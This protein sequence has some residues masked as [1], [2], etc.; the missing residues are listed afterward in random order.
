[1]REQHTARPIRILRIVTRLNV[2]GPSIHVALLSTALDPRRFA[3]CLVIG[4]PAPT[5][6]DLSGRVEGRPEVR[7]IRVA[8]LRRSIHPW[9]DAVAFARLLRILWVERPHVLHTHMAKAGALGRLAGMLYNR[10]GPGRA[11]GTRAILI[12]TFHGHVLEGYFPLWVSRFFLIIERW[13]ARGTDCLIAVSPAVQRELVDKGIGRTDQWRLIPLGMNLS[14]LGQLPLPNGA[15]PA[16]IGLVGR[17]VPIKNPSLFLQA[18]GRIQGRRPELVASGVV[19]GDGPLRQRLEQ[20]AERLGL[21]GVLRFA[22]WQQDLPSV[23]EVLEI[24]CLTS[25]NEGTPVS[26]IEAMAAGRAVVATDVGGIR[27]LLEASTEEVRAPI[28]AGAYRIAHRG[29]IVR[30]GDPEGL[31]S[32]LE[33]LASD[34][35]LRRTLGEAARTHAVRAFRQERLLHDITALYEGLLTETPCRS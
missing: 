34:A 22:G 14:V 7:V 11:A 20:E 9:S 25:W 5:E 12:H 4:R 30:A 23:Y 33:A 18:L 17:L 16:R 6:G 27:D 21:C 35:V 29:L 28:A 19:V 26:L 10:L 24:V 2:G 15:S 1:M 8:A 3:T 32:A 13:L 31:A